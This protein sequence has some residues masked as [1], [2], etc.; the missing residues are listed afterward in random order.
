MYVLLTEEWSLF[1]SLV[2]TLQV[3]GAEPALNIKQEASQTPN[4]NRF[5]IASW[6]VRVKF[7]QTLKLV[8]GWT[9][10]WSV[11]AQRERSRV[12]GQGLSK[13]EDTDWREE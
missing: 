3:L 2:E 8:L 13:E 5:K 4:Q 6:T 11:M 1:V 12:P 7:L 9:D 10:F